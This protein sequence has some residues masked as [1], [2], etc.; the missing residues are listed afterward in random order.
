[1]TVRDVLDWLDRFAP[2]ESQE[3]YDNVGLL[4][5]D[6]STEATRILFALDA[7]LAVVQEAQAQGAQLIVTHHPLMFGGISRIRYD[8]PEGAVLAAIAG[9]HISLVTAHTNLDR[10]PGGTGDSLA[11]LLS[12]TGVGLAGKSLYARMGILPIPCAAGDLLARVDHQLSSH[13]RLYGNP[14]RSVTRVAVAPG[15]AGEEYAAASQAGAQVFV[16][17]EIKHHQLLAAQAL[18]LTVIE[19]GHYYTELPGL[20][21]LYHRFTEDALSASWPV[22][23]RLSDIRPFDCAVAPSGG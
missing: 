16:V 8:E 17:G 13:A 18:G 22:E 15:A 4:M 14:A 19:A 12:L 23:T 11:A 9:A 1:M 5:G 3:D 2:F 7:T 6:P 20:T 10:A 21:A